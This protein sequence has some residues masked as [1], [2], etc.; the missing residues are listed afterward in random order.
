M[1]LK[2]GMSDEEKHKWLEENLERDMYVRTDNGI[3]RFKFKHKEGDKPY[4]FYYFKKKH[5]TNPEY[6]IIGEPSFDIIDLIQEG[7]YVNGQL[8]NELLGTAVLTGTEDIPIKNE[9]IE[10]IVT[11]EQM[12]AMQYKV[13]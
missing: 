6:Y 8:V 4:Y 3:D 9:E 10:T 11:K 7:D 2:V 13:V 1:K 5:M 12:E